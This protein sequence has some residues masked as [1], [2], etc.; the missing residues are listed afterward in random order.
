MATYP[1]SPRIDFL[2]WCQAHEAA[3]AANPAA[4][5]LTAAQATDFAEQTHQVAG[6]ELTQEL[7]LQAAKVATAQ[8]NGAYAELRAQAGDII[9]SIRAFAE[10]QNDPNAVYGLAQIPA[11]AASTPAPPPAEPTHLTV[12]LQP[13]TGDLWLRWKA[14]NPDGTSGTSYIIRRRLPGETQF[15]FIGVSGKKKFI[16]STLVA[17]PDSV[18]YTVQGQRA[19]LTGP[20][21]QVFT[22]TFGKLPDG[23]R[24]AYV[25]ASAPAYG[26][27]A[28]GSNGN[29]HAHGRAANGFARMGV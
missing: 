20:L 29:G 14:S 17:G 27:A 28:A 9:R 10:L 21:S 3:F 11:P 8:V 15:T 12:Q 23:G 4:L 22:V 24:M 13:Q 19:D 1:T 2:Q 6:A 18:Q 25:G 26:V 7:A 16:D 5:G